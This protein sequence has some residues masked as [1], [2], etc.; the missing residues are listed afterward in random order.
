MNIETKIV[1]RDYSDYLKFGWNK[2]EEKRVRYGPHHH[3]EYVL[4]RDIDIKNYPQIVDLERKY[5]SLKSQIKTYQPMDPLWG[6][7]SFLCLI[8]PFIIYAVVKSNQKKEI[9][10]NNDNLRRQMDA[11]LK[12]VQPLL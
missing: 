10:A 5:F 12:L 4:T 2:S 11:I 1:R 9:S 3:T 7:V 6:V 8:I